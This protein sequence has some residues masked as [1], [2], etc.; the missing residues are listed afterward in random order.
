MVPN[1]IPLTD[2]HPPLTDTHPQPQESKE[3][4]VSP[5]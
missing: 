4:C 2:T 5:L 3:V 1:V